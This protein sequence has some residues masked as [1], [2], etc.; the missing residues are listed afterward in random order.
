VNDFK[1]VNQLWQKVYVE[2]LS[3]LSSV[4]SQN[5]HDV[6]CEDVYHPHS[7]YILAKIG[8]S[9]IGTLRLVFDS[10]S[11]GLP[12]EQFFPLDILKD[13]KGSTIEA[14]RLMLSPEYRKTRL[15]EAPFGISASLLKAGFHYCFQKKVSRI[16]IDAFVD[17]PTT[18]IKTFKSIG[19]KEIGCPFVDSELS[20]SSLSVAMVIDVMQLLSTTYSGKS[21]LLRY[22]FSPD[23]AIRFPT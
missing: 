22:I 7:T 11:A 14:H 12:V 10:D 5:K 2:E 17:T 3:W 21:K 6:L 19:F 8:D 20:E 9:V 15:S 16:F 13:D 4:P 18:P 1:A 23:S